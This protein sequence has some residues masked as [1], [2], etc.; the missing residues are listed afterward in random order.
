MIETAVRNEVAARVLKQNALFTAT[1]VSDEDVRRRRLGVGAFTRLELL[2]AAY[3][4]PV[5]EP[6]QLRELR[7]HDAKQLRRAGHA[8]AEVERGTSVVRRAV[9]P[10]RDMTAIID[11]VG[12]PSDAHL[13]C[14]VRRASIFAPLCS[15]VVRLKD[16][17]SV[18]AA[19]CDE[20]PSSAAL[21]ARWGVAILDGDD[22]VLVT[23]PSFVIRRHNHHRWWLAEIVYASLR[24]A[25]GVSQSRG[26]SSNRATAEAI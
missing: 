4:L 25:S 19:L 24:A 10:V 1:V 5:D 11:V 9:A 7:A 13:E 21:A 22:H 12:R 14:A 18:N 15:R 23:A 8:F 17:S 16:V 26:F 6:V 2:R 3:W 20:F